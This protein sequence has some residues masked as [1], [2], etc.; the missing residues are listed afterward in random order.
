MA[1]PPPPAHHQLLSRYFTVR[2]VARY[3]TLPCLSHLAHKRLRTSHNRCTPQYLL[4]RVVLCHVVHCWGR[5]R[6]DLC[7]P[8]HIPLRTCSCLSLSGL[9]SRHTSPNLPLRAFFHITLLYFSLI[10]QHINCH[11]L[12]PKKRYTEVPLQPCLAPPRFRTE[13]E[14]LLPV[15]YLLYLPAHGQPQQT[16]LNSFFL[17]RDV[18]QRFDDLLL[19]HGVPSDNS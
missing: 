15:C 11:P 9:Y 2:R 14:Y 7:T 3:V 12:M 8:L 16:L 5:P 18:L 6:P 1:S 4:L 19:P 10:S 13:P 17:H